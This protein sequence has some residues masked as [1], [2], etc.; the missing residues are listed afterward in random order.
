M[1]IA[2]LYRKINAVQWYHRFEIVPG[3]FTPGKLPTNAKQSF[4]HF[5]IPQ[6]LTGK[7][8]LEIGTWDGPIAFEAE[9]RGAT[10]TALD[11][12]DPSRTGFNVAKEILGANVTYI[13]GSVYDATKL[14]QKNFDY[15]FCLG[16]F[17]HL[18]HPVMAF[19]E[20]SKLLKADGMLVFEGEC[21]RFYCEDETGTKVENEHIRELANSN[22]P[23]TLFYANTFKADDTNWFIPNFACLKGWLAAAGFEIER[24]SFYEVP[25]S[26]PPLQRVGGVARRVAGLKV[27]HRVQ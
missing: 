2:T 11:I 12:Q 19:E 4:S 24:H 20:I 27:E 26:N 17:Y 16:V 15:V 1:N 21:L 14:L 3:I 10:V 13:Q 22:I 8:V 25:E 23:L 5:Q 9:A 18:K 7:E 6:D